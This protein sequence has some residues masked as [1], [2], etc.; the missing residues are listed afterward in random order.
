MDQTE[1]NTQLHSRCLHILRK[2]C[3]RAGT[4]LTG[5]VLSEGLEKDGKEALT[6]GGFA[7]IWLGKYKGRAVAL[8]VLRIYGGDNIKLVKKVRSLAHIL[9]MGSNC[10]LQS[11]CREAVLWK[12]LSHPNILPFLGVSTTL[13]SLC[14]VCEWMGNGNVMRY[15]KRNPA[16]NRLHLV[17]AGVR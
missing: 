17:L 1:S 4:L 9:T 11:F 12:R 15:L 8:K 10:N 13:F 6:S 5:C 14:M 16:A 7:D 3:G 2:L